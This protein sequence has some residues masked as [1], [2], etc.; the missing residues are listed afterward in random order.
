MVD[1]NDL[2]I[3]LPPYLSAQSTDELFAD[4]EKFPEHYGELYTSYLPEPNILYQGDGISGLPMLYAD[5]EC[6]DITLKASIILSNTCDMDSRNKRKYST[7]ILYCPIFKLTEFRKGIESTY[8]KNTADSLISGIKKQACT[9]V[10]YLPAWQSDQD[11]GI[12]FLDR[13][14]HIHSSKIDLSRVSENRIFSLSNFGF[15]LLLL[16][17]SIHFCRMQ[18]KVDRY[19]LHH[20]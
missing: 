12:V 9:S 16:K 7:Y 20:L 13:I 19:V 15:Y 2:Q 4:I 8:G 18:E 6:T 17:L 5:G 10:L 11:E 1:I 14:F 3:T